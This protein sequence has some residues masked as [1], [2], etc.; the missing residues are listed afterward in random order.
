MCRRKE[1]GNGFSLLDF[2]L[3]LILIIIFIF[4]LIW[5]YPMPNLTGYYDSVFGN[6]IETMKDAAQDY[7]TNE[8]LPKIDGD[9]VRMTLQEMLDK[10]LLIPFDQSFLVKSF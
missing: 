10:K 6:N 8:R 1:N 5:L 4:L 9:S 2:L 3:R 7:Y